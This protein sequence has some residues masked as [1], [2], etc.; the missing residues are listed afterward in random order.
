LIAWAKKPV[1]CARHSK[2]TCWARIWFSR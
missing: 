1:A 2:G